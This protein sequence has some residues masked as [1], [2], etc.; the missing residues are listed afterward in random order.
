M[1]LLLGHGN[2]PLS[3]TP[4][5]SL[6]LKKQQLKLIKKLHLVKLNKNMSFANDMWDQF[7][8]I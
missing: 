3:T 8:L 4:D 2:M 1:N 5:L 6:Q 7:P